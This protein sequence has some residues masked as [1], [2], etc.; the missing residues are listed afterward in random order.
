MLNKKFLFG[1]VLTALVCLTACSKDGNAEPETTSAEAAAASET[2]TASESLV[3]ESE[4]TNETVPEVIDPYAAVEKYIEELAENENVTA[5]EL[6]ETRISQTGAIAYKYYESPLAEE[7]GVAEGVHMI[8][9]NVDYYI[10]YAENSELQ[11]GERSA[12]FIIKSD[13]SGL[14]VVDIFAYE[15]KEYYGE[16]KEVLTDEEF[17]S[18]HYLVELDGGLGTVEC[19]N[20]AFFNG[21]EAGQRI[22]IEA[23]GD[24]YEDPPRLD[25]IVMFDESEMPND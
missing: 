6:R 24:I 16:I 21:F 20:A 8:P 12:Y 18:E 11:S 7:F 25:A 3:S 2:T 15:P 4:E 22:Y 17:Y 14:A 10:E 9:V 19:I 13:E 5:V 1:A 23:N